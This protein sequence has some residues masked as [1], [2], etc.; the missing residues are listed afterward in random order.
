MKTIAKNP[1]VMYDFYKY[2]KNDVLALMGKFSYDYKVL[3]IAGLPKSGT[4]WMETQ[5]ARYPGYN[6][7]YFQ[8]PDGCV[9]EHDIC[10]SVFSS[11]P[12]YRYSVLKL[13]T[14][15]SKRNYET[16][17]K[18]VPRFVVMIRDLRDMCVSRY[19][20]VKKEKTHRH[21]ELYNRE[22]VEVGLMH[23]ITVIEEEYVSWVNDWIKA[24]RDNPDNIM[25]ITYEELNCSPEETFK[26]VTNFFHLPVRTDFLEDAKRS[27]LQGERNL[28]QELEKN[29]GIIKSTKRKGT[30]GDWKNYFSESHKKKFKE[31]AGNLMIELG[32]EKDMNW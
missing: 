1:E 7:R 23:C 13:H 24:C 4:T 20:H 6:I 27:N 25:L 31:I 18:Y 22:S 12:K 8:D 3:Y 16:I 2:L 29:F 17:R 10:D 15:Y 9:Y 14:K 32:Y 19:F 28:Q 21:Y 11:L 5:L 26:K 30:I